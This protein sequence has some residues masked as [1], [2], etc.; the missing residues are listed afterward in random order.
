MNPDLPT[1]RTL[2]EGAALADQ[3]KFDLNITNNQKTTLIRSEYIMWGSS[4]EAS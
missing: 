3:P 4:L 2:A 1:E